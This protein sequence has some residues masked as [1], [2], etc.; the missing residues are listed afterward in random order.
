[1]MMLGYL[2]F[3]LIL[4]RINCSY[5][6]AKCVVQDQKSNSNLTDC[7]ETISV[8]ELILEGN[9][10]VS[11]DTELIFILPVYN[12][13]GIIRFANARAVTLTGTYPTITEIKCSNGAGV[14][15][16][17]VD[18]V[19]IN[20]VNFTTCGAN[21]DGMTIAVG[22]LFCNYVTIYNL[23]VT[24][25]HGIG[26]YF[27]NVSKSINVSSSQ[28]LSDQISFS[29]EAVSKNISKVYV[30]VSQQDGTKY[31]FF[32][33]VFQNKENQDCDISTIKRFKRQHSFSELISGGGIFINISVMANNVEIEIVSC[34]FENNVAPNGGGLFLNIQDDTENISVRI[35]D[36]VFRG[37]CANDSGGGVCIH[38]KQQ[39][40]NIISNN[41]TLINN[42]F[43]NNTAIYGGGVFLS[44]SINPNSCEIKNYVTFE[45]CR[46]LQNKAVLG[47]AVNIKPDT[48][49]SFISKAILLEPLFHNCVFEGNSIQSSPQETIG[50]NSI[51]MVFGKG[52]LYC[53]ELNIRFQGDV[54][55]T[56]NNGSAVFLVSSIL[57]ISNSN[58]T[59]Q[60][61]TG[62]YGGGITMLRNSVIHLDDYAYVSFV[63]NSADRHGGALFQ[64]TY[65]DP[66]ETSNHRCFIRYI[67]KYKECKPSHVIFENNSIKGKK[68][69]SSE[70]S[71]GL[72]LFLYSLI[73]C[74][75]SH[76][77]ES[78]VDEV[79]RSIANITIMDYLSN[80]DVSTL[81][82]K[83]SDVSRLPREFIPG[84]ETDLK[85]VVEDDTQT[86]VPHATF[87]AKLSD[88]KSSS[89]IDID[90]AYLFVS[91]NT[92]KLTG[93]PNSS[94]TLQILVSKKPYYQLSVPVH[95]VDCP[96]GYVISGKKC[97]CSANVNGE[98]YKGIKRCNL[99]LFQANLVQGYWA[100][101]VGKNQDDFRTSNCPLNFCKVESGNPELQLPQNRSEMDN[102]LCSKNR[103][104]R[105][106]SLC[107]EGSSLRYHTL[108]NAHCE[109]NSKCSLGI[110][111]YIIAEII[112]VTIFFLF[113][114]LF[115]V[116]LTSGALSG[117]LFYVQVFNTLEINAGNFIN[118]PI[119]AG[120]LLTFLKFLIGVFNLEF[121]L[122]PKLSF[123]IVKG[124]TYMHL[125]VFSYV[126]ILYAL[127][128][129]VGTVLVVNFRL[130]KLLMKITGKKNYKNPSII[131]GLSSFLLICFS[132]ST[133]TSLQILNSVTLF[134]KNGKAEQRVVYY[135]GE[136]NFFGTEHIPFAILA[137][138]ALLLT[139][140][141]VVLLLVYPACHHFMAFLGLEQSKLNR[142]LCKVF[143]LDK[144]KPFF[145]SF[146]S[147]FKDDHRYFAGLFFVYRFMS[148]AINNITNSHTKFYFGLEVQL[149]LILTFHGLIQPH[150]THW[151]N[152][153]DIVFLALLAI[154]NGITNYNFHTLNIEGESISALITLQVLLAYLPIVYITVLGSFM[155]KQKTC[156]WWLKYHSNKEDNLVDE[157]ANDELLDMLDQDENDLISS[158][159]QSTSE[160]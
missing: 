137:L 153:I 111:F 34:V 25:S 149:I 73:P 140:L 14:V 129:I 119:T 18:T 90:P 100:G 134:G 53:N 107:R 141:P 108:Q 70:K 37:N 128:L 43:T 110:L 29:D 35:V 143:P 24:N 51:I 3:F 19:S 93:S 55:F 57:T 30:D 101:Y 60:N 146:Q 13:S 118:L 122:L 87:T 62:Y 6:D 69:V 142:C 151:H 144:L 160:S 64:E 59:F 123:C 131:H 95:L 106:C 15:F 158:Y 5:G 77:S 61:N 86:V 45:E 21:I 31:R 117:F 76:N 148:L 99:T 80:S 8:D 20:N 67:G 96:P 56:R 42:N 49:N 136:Y 46:Y 83:F 115:D 114:I 139:S 74:F 126:T 41:I 10:T 47:S 50:M 135:H 125:L 54:M 104:G 89:D 11:N 16:T 102:I 155:I 28:F 154:L 1:M 113:I 88:H 98:S 79:L 22:I 91:N 124:A 38:F 152:Q 17:F 71:I 63:N 92:I 27:K 105:V 82:S 52:S 7:K 36:S 159:Q 85:I 116:K 145:D 75:D 150:K 33:C 94:A 121:F 26:L 72:S 109:S 81:P 103:H 157:R 78:E 84:E 138:A 120:T 32:D 2:A 65:N 40:E 133:K 23:R 97:E 12:I 147:T 130:G 132:R 68:R 112:P 48:H 9:N 58:T 156:K 127:M 39:N 44:V 66:Y 4:S